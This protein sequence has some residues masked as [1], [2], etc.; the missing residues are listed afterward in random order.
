MSS[1]V[2]RRI[3]SQLIDSLCMNVDEFDMS[4][5]LLKTLTSA[6]INFVAQVLSF[7]REKLD[8]EVFT[9]IKT[10]DKQ[11]T[12]LYK[13]LA[14]SHIKIWTNRLL[15]EGIRSMGVDELRAHLEA[16]PDKAFEVIMSEDM[17]EEGERLIKEREALEGRIKAL[18]PTELKD[19]LKSPFLESV[20]RQV[21]RDISAPDSGIDDLNDHD[22]IRGVTQKVISRGLGFG[23]E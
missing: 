3:R 18:L 7:S 10:R 23:G 21:A 2:P 22:V 13:L 8:E 12:E 9:N 19:G 16:L 5:G 14:P 20:I 4:V 15:S 6:K 1:P 11:L 17:K